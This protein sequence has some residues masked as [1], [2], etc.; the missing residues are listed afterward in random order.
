[1][2]KS[3]FLLL[4]A[5]IAATLLCTVTGLDLRAAALFYRPGAGFPIGDQQPWHAL[6]RF[7]EY[8]AFA[9]GA[10]AALSL[11]AGFL[12]PP[13]ARYRRRALFLVLLLVIAPGLLTNSLFKDH[14]GRPRPRQLDMFG[15]TM[16]FH[17]PWQPGPA[18]KNAS[19]PAGHPTVAFYLSAPYFVLRRSHRRQGLIWLSG[20]IL[21]GIVMGMARV[22]QGGH[23]VTDVIWSAGFVF[24]SALVLASLLR[25]D[26]ESETWSQKAK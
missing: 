6:Y 23:F 12:L 1:M 20:G 9:M 15:G 5:L 8:P 24:L 3:F 14:W 16:A 11:V 10:V 18:P 21:Y 22:I 26:E 17:E 2:G 4:A 13:L 25:P 19:F 7:G